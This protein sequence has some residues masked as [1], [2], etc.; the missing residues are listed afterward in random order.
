[1]LATTIVDPTGVSDIM[2]ITIP[3]KA[4]HT[5]IIAE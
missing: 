2:E 3:N 4:Q 1:M 5:E